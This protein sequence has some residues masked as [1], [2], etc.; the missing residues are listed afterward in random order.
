M[1]VMPSVVLQPLDLE[2]HLLAQLAV[3]RAERLVHQRQAR[4][5]HD[6]PGQGDAL[7]LAAAQLAGKRSPYVLELHEPQRLVDPSSRLGLRHA[8][9]LQRE[10]D[11]LGDAHVREQ[12][13]VLEHH[14]DVAL[15]R[16]Q[17]RDLAVA[18]DDRPAR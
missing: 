3:E 12:G 13:V 14:A 4:L 8:A 9:H 5:E 7:L 11:V 16:R 15:V 2:L 18:D 1:T 10:A 17:A 6:G